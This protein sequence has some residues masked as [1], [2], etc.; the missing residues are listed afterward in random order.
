MP[1]N[2]AAKLKHLTSAKEA[3]FYQVFVGLLLKWL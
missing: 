2:F 3:M 1:I